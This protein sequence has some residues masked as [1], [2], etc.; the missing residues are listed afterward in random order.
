VSAKNIYHNAVVRAW[1]ADGWTITDDPLRVEYGD[2]NIYVDLGAER[3]TLGAEKAG[4][5][6][7]VEIQSFLGLSP[8][9]DLEEA[10]GQYK[11]YQ[12]ILAEAKPDRQIYMAVPIRVYESLLT[13][14]FGR[15]IVSQLGLRLLVFDHKQER[16]Y[17]W[18]ELTATA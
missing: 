12:T 17:Q 8:L 15:L 13:E 7:A 4:R 18:I 6:I 3:T 5:K 11:V 1:E 9:R 16:I 2:R 14:R 10:V